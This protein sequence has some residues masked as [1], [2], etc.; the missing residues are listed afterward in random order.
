M[1]SINKKDKVKIVNTNNIWQNKE[2][3]VLD[4]DIDE[5]DLD[6]SYIRVSIDFDDKKVIQTFPYQNIEIINK[7]ESLI[8]DIHFDTEDSFVKYFTG[9]DVVF[10]GYDYDD[11]YVKHEQDNGSYDYNADDKEYID[12]YEYLKTIPCTIYR[13]ALCDYDRDYS[14]S[15]NFKSAYWDLKFETGDLLQA[16]QG[17]FIKLK[18][19]SL[20]KLSEK[21]ESK[22]D[23]EDII[24]DYVRIFDINNEEIPSW[25]FVDRISAAENKKQDTIIKIARQFKYKIYKL[26]ANK[27][28]KYIVADPRC[29][30]ESIYDDYADYLQGNIELS[31][32]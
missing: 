13:C 17:E 24:K 27:F 21:L 22:N 6:N 16:V 15:E 8:E 4:T 20:S 19:I 9:K 31:E 3:V 10:L 1:S 5:A 25:F 26:Q 28:L 30:E 32:V 2:G 12:Y 18:N 7:N 11:L 29:T 14:V 23:S